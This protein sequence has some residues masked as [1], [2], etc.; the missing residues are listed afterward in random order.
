[1]IVHFNVAEMNGAVFDEKSQEFF[2]L[3]S[4]L[5]SFLQFRSNAKMNK[6]ERFAPS[7]SGSKKIQKKKGGK[8]EGPTAAAKGKGKTKVAIKRKCFH[9]KTVIHILNNVPSKS[10]LKHLSSYEV[11]VV[12]LDDGVEDPLSYKQAMNDVDKDQWVKVMNLEMESM[13][14]NLVW[15]LVDL[16]E[17]GIPKGKRVDYEET[18]SLIAMLKSIRILLSIATFYDY[19]I[20]QMDVKTAF[21]NGNLEESIFMS[22]SEGFDTAIKS[23]DFDQNIDEPCV[24]KKINKGIQE[25]QQSPIP[26]ERFRRSTICSWD[27]NHK[28]SHG[29]HLFKEQCPKT[30]QE[31]EDMRRIPYASAVGSLMYV[32]LYTKLDIC[33]AVGIVNRY[34]SNLGFDHW[35][36]VKI[37]LKYLRTMRDYMLMYGVKDLIIIAYTYSD[38]QT[39]KDSRK[40]ISGSE[41]IINGRAVV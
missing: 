17:E 35:T 30:P 41:F 14:F 32:M 11:D 34:Q 3:K 10:V 4:L 37:I 7:S 38:F 31:V 25:N 1:M 9:L 15:E 5:K 16:P 19:E 36:L 40:F 24:Y 22:Q 29:V 39:D 18:F 20:W 23:Y 13:Y 2:I 6:I 33:Y 21:L 26:N 8:G 28:G 12:I 27:P